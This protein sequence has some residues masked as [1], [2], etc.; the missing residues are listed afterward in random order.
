MKQTGYFVTPGF[1]GGPAWDETL[2]GVVGMIV[3]ADTSPGVRVAFIIPVDRLIEAWPELARPT[4]PSTLDLASI[5]IAWDR[6]DN[7]Y[8]L[9]R[10][11][12]YQI[13]H[14]AEATLRDVGIMLGRRLAGRK[15]LSF[16]ELAQF[17]EGQPVPDTTPWIARAREDGKLYWIKPRIELAQEGQKLEWKVINQK[18]EIVNEQTRLALADD[19]T[20][21][22][23]LRQELD[24]YM[25]LGHIPDYFGTEAELASPRLIKGKEWEHQY[26]QLG[27]IW[28]HVPYSIK[29]L[30]REMLGELSKIEASSNSTK[31]KSRE[32]QFNRLNG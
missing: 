20:T 25:S 13:P 16:E 18:K 15:E 6:V 8:L 10:G 9:Y 5:D 30:T 29:I 31:A 22:T 3:A 21:T 26:V 2:D 1:S 24:R 28:R 17:S 14:Q 23:V 32:Y 27:R 19:V 4:V 11:V 7:Y 12:R